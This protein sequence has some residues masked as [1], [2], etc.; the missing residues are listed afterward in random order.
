VF[1]AYCPTVL[2]ST[3]HPPIPLTLIGQ[4]PEPATANNCDLWAQDAQRW[5]YRW[6]NLLNAHRASLGLA[7]VGDVRTHIFTNQPWLAADPTLAPWPDAADPAVVQTGAWMI[8]DKRPLSSELE[9]F[10]AAGEPPV[11]FGFGSMSAPD[12]LATVILRAAR[13]LGRRAILL[14]GWANLSVTDDAPDCLVIGEVNQQ[15]LFRRVAVVVHHGGAG[16][17]TAAG[18]AGNHRSS[19]PRCT[20]STT[21]QSVSTSFKL[22]ARSPPARRPQPL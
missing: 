16:T 11:Y 22:A 14:R 20:T 15:A 18:L 19:F 10:L 21:G 12:D 9:A 7:P 17:T 13:A 3:L 5:H 4:T 8:A 6:G 2:P 1:V